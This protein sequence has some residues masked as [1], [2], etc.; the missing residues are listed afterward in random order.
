MVVHFG[1]EGHRREVVPS[2]VVKNILLL[3]KLASVSS[4]VSVGAGTQVHMG[5]RQEPCC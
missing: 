4:S 2:F 1:H 5:A 3:L